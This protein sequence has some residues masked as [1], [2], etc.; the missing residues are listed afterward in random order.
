MSQSLL[1]DTTPIRNDKFLDTSIVSEVES[2]PFADK[3][4]TT[5]QN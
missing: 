5:Y 1:G 3:S 4:I 2:L